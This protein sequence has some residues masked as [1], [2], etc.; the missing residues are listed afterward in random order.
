MSGIDREIVLDS[1]H[2]AKHLPDTPQVQRLLKRG[3]SAHVFK[4][5]ATMERVAQAIIEGGEFI[6]IIRGYERYGLFFADAI[7]YRISPT[8]GSSTFL[9]YGEVKIDA[10]NRYH[11]IPRTR[12]SQA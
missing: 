10:E 3:R 2:I 12:P 9:F 6:G 7:G 8:D 11:V 4:D 1:R 5:Q